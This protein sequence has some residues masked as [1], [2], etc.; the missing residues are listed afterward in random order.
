MGK[1]NHLEIGNTALTDNRKE[2]KDTELKQLNRCKHISS[3]NWKLSWL[4]WKLSRLLC[5]EESKYTSIGSI[6]Q[7]ETQ[8]R[9]AT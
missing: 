3:R 8:E 1:E 6:K 7:K 2:H 5:T 9:K 4:N